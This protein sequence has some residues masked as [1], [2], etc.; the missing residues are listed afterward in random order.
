MNSQINIKCERCGLD[1]VARV[2]ADEWNDTPASFT[3]TRE[4]R[5]CG[6]SYD[7]MTAQDMH[8]LTGL[9]KAGWLK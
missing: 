3:I 7:T 9:S 6:K 5:V 2:T 8:E 1:A 4:C